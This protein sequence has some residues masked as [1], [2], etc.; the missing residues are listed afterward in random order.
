MHLSQCC[1]HIINT[2][3]GILLYIFNLLLL[4][5]SILSVSSSKYEVLHKHSPEE[6]KYLLEL[7]KHS[8]Q[9][10]GPKSS[11]VPQVESQTINY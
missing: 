1:L 4:E 5:H 9:C 6:V 3:N 11:Q 7:S 2:S 10:V 8:I